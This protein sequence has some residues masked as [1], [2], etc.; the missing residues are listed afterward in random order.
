MEARDGKMRIRN[1]SDDETRMQRRWTIDRTHFSRLIFS[2]LNNI[3][4]ITV[5]LH[6]LS[7]FRII[8][9]LNNTRDI[10]Q[11]YEFFRT[12]LRLR[13]SASQY[14]QVNLARLFVLLSRIHIFVLK[15]YT[16]SDLFLI[17]RTFIKFLYMKSLECWAVSRLSLSRVSVAGVAIY[18]RGTKPPVSDNETPQ[19]SPRV[20]F[21]SARL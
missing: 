17:I 19:T 2:G 18:S 5:F 6:S 14:C 15:A 8:I 13:K 20:V 16:C 21:L 7:V 9:A 1:V 10:W 12:N 4:I 11:N 3:G